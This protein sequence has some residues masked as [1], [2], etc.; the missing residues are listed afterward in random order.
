M[1]IHIVRNGAELGS[2]EVADAVEL[3]RDGFLR[4]TDEFWVEDYLQRHS[5]EELPSI[6][7]SSDSSLLK[8]ARKRA[9]ATREIIRMGAEKIGRT[10]AAT[11]AAAKVAQAKALEGYLPRLRQQTVD[12]LTKSTRST[13]AA[14]K[15]E[16]FLQKLFG[17]VYDCTP[18]PVRRFISEPVFI[19][20][21]LKH[22]RKLLG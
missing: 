19:Q 11:G 10:A 9:A 1:K 15:D 3:L 6:A 4:K 8:L 20:F 18:K 12:A 16:E 22:R 17:A 13:Q 2:L 5:L 7:K 14:L 21:C